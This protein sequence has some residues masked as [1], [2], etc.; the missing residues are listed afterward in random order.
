MSKSASTTK[1]NLLVTKAE[2]N[3]LGWK[4]GKTHIDEVADLNRS[5]IKYGVTTPGSIMMLLA[6]AMFETD[7]GRYPTEKYAQGSSYIMGE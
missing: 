5:L 7:Y 1:N 4:S 2:M 3:A 6:S